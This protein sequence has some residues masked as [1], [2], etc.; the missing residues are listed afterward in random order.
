MTIHSMKLK[1]EFFDAVQCGMKNFEVRYD[2]RG[3]RIGDIVEMKRTFD[4]LPPIDDD[5]VI[6][7][8]I[9]YILRHEDFPDALKE[10]YVVLGLS[11][12]EVSG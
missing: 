7:R 5:E 3:F 4:G 2:D 8:R 6:K 11:P 9:V 10:G 12:M 1:D